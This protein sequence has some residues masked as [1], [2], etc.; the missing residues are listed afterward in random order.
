[1]CRINDVEK[2]AL[3]TRLT[4]RGPERLTAVRAA[5]AGAGVS[6]DQFEWLL[7]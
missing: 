2:S 7:T 4:T 6:G 3:L 1:M 5:T